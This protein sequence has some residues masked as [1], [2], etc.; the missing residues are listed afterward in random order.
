MRL[1]LNKCRSGALIGALSSLSATR[2]PPDAEPMVS[3]VVR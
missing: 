2:Q 1:E 3:G